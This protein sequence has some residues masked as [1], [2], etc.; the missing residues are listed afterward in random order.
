MKKTVLLISGIIF[1][2][3]LACAQHLVK[4]DLFS[5]VFPYEPVR[6]VQDIETDGLGIVQ[7]IS[8]IY[9]DASTAWMIA[10]TEYPAEHMQQS[11]LLESAKNGFITSLE[12]VVATEWA[13]S[14]D[15]YEGIYFQAGNEQT[16]C[17]L[18]DFI[19]GNRLYQ[20]GILQSDEYPSEEVVDRFINSFN[21]NL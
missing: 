9:E 4:E 12:L 16:F 10:Y 17:V 11:G 5:I 14:K 7:M 6:Q 15:I 13:I 21:L 3:A 1:L 18:K 20:I 8:Y 19:V 2:S